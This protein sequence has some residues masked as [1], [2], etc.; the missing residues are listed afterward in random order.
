MSVKSRPHLRDLYGEGQ[1]I[2]VKVWHADELQEIP[3]WLRRPNPIDQQEAQRK[4]RGARA[5]TKNRLREGDERMALEQEVGDL[6]KLGV[7]E[8]LI[9]FS[10]A[11]FEAAAQNDV[12]YS[13][14]VGD[15]WSEEGKDLHAVT[16]GY[17]ARWLEIVALNEE[18]EAEETELVKPEEDVELQKLQDVISDF[19]NQIKKRTLELIESET[20]T[21]MKL[22]RSTLNKQLIDK[23]IEVEADLEFYQEYQ[24]AM[25]YFSC[26]DPE[27]HTASYFQSP[28]EIL[29]YPQMVRTQLTTAYEAQEM[30]VE[31]IKNWLSLL[32]SSD[33]LE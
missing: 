8:Q 3:I 5:R 7:C 16:E 31:N 26:R 17:Q 1:E 30:G 9:D 20:T 14:A 10:K 21:L 15:D 29:E 6:A 11:E 19:E 24:L 13:D 12:L 33:S 22:K 2:T 32:S 4:G 27:D 18:H 28:R 25:L 23:N